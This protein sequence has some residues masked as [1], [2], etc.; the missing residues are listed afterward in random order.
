MRGR[1]VCGAPT[2]PAFD[3]SG[4]MPGGR[5][6]VDPNVLAQGGPS[7]LAIGRIGPAMGSPNDLTYDRNVPA[8]AGPND[9]PLV[10][11][12]PEE[13]PVAQEISNAR[14]RHGQGR[15]VD[16]NNEHARGKERGRVSTPDLRRVRGPNTKTVPVLSKVHDRSSGRDLSKA[17]DRTT[18]AAANSGLDRKE[19]ERRNELRRR[20]CCKWSWYVNYQPADCEIS[21]RLNNIRSNVFRSNQS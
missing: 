14:R 9:L 20:S 21:R 12:V 16:R 7:G 19:V 13:E 8:P 18:E 4:Q 1:R 2:V 5:R 15:K 6:A 3:Q 11:S 10:Q 17:R